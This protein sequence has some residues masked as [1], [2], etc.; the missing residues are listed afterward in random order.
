MM[1][2][3]DIALVTVI[4]FLFGLL[5]SFAF[6]IYTTDKEY[7]KIEYQ[8]TCSEGFQTDWLKRAYVR[9]EGTVLY[10]DE[11]IYR[12]QLGE[13]CERSKRISDTE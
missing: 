11:G 10:G 1:S 3:S 5:V 8:V 9:T 6:K 7:R 2:K 4:L 12:I 13:H